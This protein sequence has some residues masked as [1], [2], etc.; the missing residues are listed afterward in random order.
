MF[1]TNIL[2][3]KAMKSPSFKFLEF[4][5]SFRDG[6][7]LKT[8]SFTIVEF[9]TALQHFYLIQLAFQLLHDHLYTTRSFLSSCRCCR[10]N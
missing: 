10:S 3:L 6:T 8:T 4:S 5:K 9:W 1:L 2:V 7:E